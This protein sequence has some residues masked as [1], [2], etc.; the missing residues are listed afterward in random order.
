M[1]WGVA[2]G[3]ITADGIR[4]ALSEHDAPLKFAGLREPVGIGILDSLVTHG[5]LDS[6]FTG[7]ACRAVLGL[8]TDRVGTA[9]VLRRAMLSP[10]LQFRLAMLGVWHE[11]THEGGFR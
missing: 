7:D 2:T 6:A 5:E 3:Q 11:G 8:I 9:E 10:V 4:A 1:E